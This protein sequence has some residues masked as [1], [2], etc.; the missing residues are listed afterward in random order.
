MFTY[1]D[2]VVI[3]LIA[4]AIIFFDSIKD[5]LEI[6]H[7]GVFIDQ[8]ALLMKKTNKE[9]RQMLEGHRSISNLKK[10]DLVELVML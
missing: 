6:F 2:R 7:R 9:L 5:L 3:F 8:R 1:T 10:V 4:T